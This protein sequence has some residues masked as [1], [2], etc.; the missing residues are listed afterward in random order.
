MSTPSTYAVETL[1]RFQY[2]Q[3]DVLTWRVTPTGEFTVRSTY[4]LAKEK[5]E[6]QRGEESKS[7]RYNRIWK[8]KW[9]LQVPNPVRVFLWLACNDILPTKENL[10]KQGIV[11]ESNCIFCQMKH[12]SA[13]HVLWRCPSASDVREACGKNCAK[14][15]VKWEN[16]IHV[17]ERAGLISLQWRQ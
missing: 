5:N 6:L 9:S 15:F 14:E 7:S 10:K 17:L 16:F 4:H 13:L 3:Q 12:E 2:R 1:R 8:S 11:K